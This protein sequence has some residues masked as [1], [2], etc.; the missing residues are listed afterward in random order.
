MKYVIGNLKMNLISSA[1]LERYFSNFKREIGNKKFSDTQIVIC[2]PAVYLEKFLKTLGN[3]TVKIGVQNIFWE[4]EVA[5]TGEI[6]A[7]MVKNLKGEYAI[8]GHSERR[9]YFGETSETS[10]LKVKSALKSGLVP[11][12]CIGESRM[13]REKGLTKD[14][15]SRQLL[16]GTKEIPAARFKEMIIVYEPIWAVGTDVVPS[17]NEIMEAKILIKKI[18]AFDLKVKTIPPILYGGSVNPVIAE[19]VCVKAGMD[20]ALVGRESL[21]P[22]DFLKIAKL[23]SC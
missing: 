20:G 3:K 2:C 7:P 17:T 8:I 12:Y 23:L 18:L 5:F 11:V 10:N 16:E 15:I 4:K 19:K 6:S 13:E 1:E 9:K 14:V 22:H 21:S